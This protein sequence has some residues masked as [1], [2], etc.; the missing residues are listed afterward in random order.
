MT[1]NSWAVCLLLASCAAPAEKPV[2]ESGVMGRDT[3]THEDRR[4]PA[5]NQGVQRSNDA[6]GVVDDESNDAPVEMT[7]LQQG[8]THIGPH[9]VQITVEKLV[10]GQPPQ[11]HLVFRDDTRELDVQFKS[12]YAEG[13]TFG[14]LYKVDVDDEALTLRVEPSNITAPIDV[15]TAGEIADRDLAERPGC[16]GDKR[17][18][19]GNPNGTVSIRVMRGEEEI[20]CQSTVGLYTRSVIE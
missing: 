3:L 14:V 4:I 1:R 9:G 17:V 8:R 20:V 16:V 12:A 19:I 10:A 5:P 15:A 6:T 11:V 7:V 18:A 2:D 13:V